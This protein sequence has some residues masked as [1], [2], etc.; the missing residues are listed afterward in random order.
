MPTLINIKE[1]TGFIHIPRTG[2]SIFSSMLRLDNNYTTNILNFNALNIDIIHKYHYPSYLLDRN[3][4][5]TSIVRNPYDRFVSCYIKAYMINKFQISNYNINNEIIPNIARLNEDINKN[6]LKLDDTFDIDNK[7]NDNFT[8]FF[9]TM[10]YFTYSE[11]KTTRYVKNILRYED[12]I[13]N[14]YYKINMDME[15]H[16]NIYPPKFK[17]GKTAIN[18]VNK[19]YDIDFKNFNY[20]K[21]IVI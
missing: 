13:S 7:P 12:L 6:F 14:I 5:L 4:F 17:L 21:I 19:L 16:L 8:I 9:K 10:T 11:D 18:F 1:N 3:I 2:G 20:E 15:E